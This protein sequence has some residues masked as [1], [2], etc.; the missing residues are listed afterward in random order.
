MSALHE[1]LPETEASAAAAPETPPAEAPAPEAVADGS[2]ERR[3]VPRFTLLIQTAK[4][5]S[6][7]GE[8]LCI[9][10]DAS[11]E[12]VRVRHFGYLP[13][14]E[15][16]EFELANGQRFTVQLAWQDEEYAGLKF[17]K[18]VN[19]AKIVKLSSS[20]FPKRQL[21][22]ATEI[23]GKVTFADV[24]CP[25]RIRNLSQQGACIE[26]GER[27][28]LQQ[29][30]RLESD[31]LEP[32]YAKVRWRKGNVYG[33]VFEETLTLER[34]AEIVA[35]AAYDEAERQEVAAQAAAAA[36]AAAASANDG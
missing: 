12:G 24:R 26:C 7:H 6:H 17:N 11:T 28:A 22:L 10:R 3:H 36:E 30:I 8:F 1:A 15:Y 25:V 14:D 13:P 9:V 20:S 29:L 21:R 33:L 4:L 34:L 19:L 18:G 16:I 2:E 32:V 27:I 5:V 35:Q 31:D 23:M